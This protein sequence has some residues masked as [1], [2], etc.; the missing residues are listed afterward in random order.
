MAAGSAQA[1]PHDKD[2]ADGCLQQLAALSAG[3]Q[4]CNKD[5]GARECGSAGARGRGSAGVR[6][7]ESVGAR[8]RGSAGVQE[9]ESAGARG[10]GSAG[11]RECGSGGARECGNAG[12]RECRSA[13]ARERGNAG[14]RER[15]WGAEGGRQVGAGFARKLRASMAQARCRAKV[16][17]PSKGLLL[18]IL[19]TSQ[20]NAQEKHGT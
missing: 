11:A 9:C 8:G 7:C 12:V 15:G 1:H 10:C 5:V 13:G 14:V 2:V 18:K 3:A 19:A 17:I 6:E 16:A 4:G 20:R